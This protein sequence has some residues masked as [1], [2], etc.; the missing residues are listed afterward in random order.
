MLGGGTGKLELLQRCLLVPRGHSSQIRWSTREYAVGVSLLP[1][2][3]GD[4]RDQR[5]AA[6]GLRAATRWMLFFALREVANVDDARRWR[7]SVRQV[8]ATLSLY[9]GTASYA[10]RQRNYPQRQQFRQTIG[11][12]VSRWLPDAALVRLAAR[13]RRRW[14]VEP[15]ASD[16]SEVAA[17]RPQAAKT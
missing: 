12:A 5:L 17:S 11:V 14:G 8:N 1:E 15:P 7:R 16:F 2:F 10:L 13:L 3:L 9:G 4:A 6:I